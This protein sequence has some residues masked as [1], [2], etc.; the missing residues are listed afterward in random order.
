MVFDIYTFVEA[1]WI[2]IPAYAANGL[3]PL[4]RG[5]HP[6]DFGRRFRGKPLFGPGK[7][8]EGLVAGSI[9][10]MII[11]FVQLSAFPYIPWGLSEVPLT[12]VPMSLQ[13]GFLLGFGTVIGD[14]CGSF[15]KRRLG[16]KRGQSA[17]VLDQDDFIV[18]A[19][20]FASL[21]VVIKWEWVVMMLIFTFIFHVI[22]SRIGYWIHV[23]REPY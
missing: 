16:L 8:W 9:I 17:P 10:G 23:K 12:I 2:V 7:T 6:V 19:F 21:L 20:V 4:F 22:A 3:I 1:L 13:L 11:A 15:I 14:M 18:G 5:K